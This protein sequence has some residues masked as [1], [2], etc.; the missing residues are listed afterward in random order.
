M[1]DFKGIYT[2]LI[3]PY[4]K[5]D[6]VNYDALGKLVEQQ[7]AEGVHGFY[8]TGSTGECFLLSR[9]ERKE[10]MEFILAKTAGRIKTI[11]HIGST[12]TKEAIELG[13]HAKLH[14]ADAISA[15]T[16]FYYK[17]SSAEIKNHYDKIVE[18]VDLPMVLYNIPTL[19]GSS[20]TTGELKELYKNPK[21]I[22][23]KHTSM[24]L[25][26]LQQ[27]K[28]VDKDII[29][30][31]GHDEVTVSGL[32]IG[33]DGAIGSTFNIIFPLVKTI[34]ELFEAGEVA[35]ARE[36]QIYMNEIICA[37]IRA[38]V[39]QGIKYVLEKRDGIECNGCRMPMH[40]I[41]E[42]SKKE[43]SELFSLSN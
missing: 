4:T 40:T 15:V 26:D 6:K 8:I 7:I 23:V 1:K 21:I 43:L 3:T 28:T 35:Q 18:E 11:V 34:T 16:P 22:G 12:S 36:K 20:L 32:A 31:N 37:L 33:A 9:E 5:D 17:Y 27:Y 10:I 39:N 41:T 29:I 42:E 19:T 25:F 24:N 30:F 13:K 38:G 2:A 14:N